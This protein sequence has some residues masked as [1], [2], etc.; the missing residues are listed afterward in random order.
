MSL[1]LHVPSDDDDFDF[2]ALRWRVIVEDIETRWLFSEVRWRCRHA[3]LGEERRRMNAELNEARDDRDR[4][5][6]KLAAVTAA[7]SDDTPTTPARRP[8]SR[9]PAPLT[10]QQARA[11]EL[12]FQHK[13]FAAAAREMGVSRQALRRLYEDGHAKMRRANDQVADPARRRPRRGRK[14]ALPTD[15]RGQADVAG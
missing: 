4:A 7:L 6:A 11:V 8:P 9:G 2:E 14:Q 3:Q 15:R 13:S 12:V 10:E 5:E 1:D